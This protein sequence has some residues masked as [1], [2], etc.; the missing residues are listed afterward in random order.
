MRQSISHLAAIAVIAASYRPAISRAAILEFP[1]AVKTPALAPFDAFV[2][3][4]EAAYGGPIDA[5]KAS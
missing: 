2:D 3:W 1:S 5:G 4:L